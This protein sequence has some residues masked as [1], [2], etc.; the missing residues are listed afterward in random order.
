MPRVVL[1]GS[2]EDVL[3]GVVAEPGN[4]GAGGRVA[5]ADGLFE[6]LLE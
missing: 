2:T 3:A 6:A 5:D 1:G 4:P